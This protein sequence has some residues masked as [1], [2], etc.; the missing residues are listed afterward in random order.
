MPRSQSTPRRGNTHN[1]YDTASNGSV[2]S[3][4]SDS[5]APAPSHGA[6]R[7]NVAQAK[8]IV[9]QTAARKSSLVSQGSRG[10]RPLSMEW[11]PDV[12]N[13]ELSSDEASQLATLDET[14][15][16]TRE[17][18][19]LS[20]SG[21][22]LG[23]TIHG[24][25]DKMHL[26]GDPSIYVTAVI[27]DHAASRDGRL[28]VGDKILS[29]NGLSMENV[30]HLEAVRALKM[31]PRIVSLEVAHGAMLRRK[32]ELLKLRSGLE[33]QTH[34]A[35]IQLHKL[36]GGLGFSIAGGVG[37]PH[38]AGDSGIF[39]VK[40]AAGGAAELD[41]RLSVGDKLLAINGQTCVGIDHDAAVDYLKSAHGAVMLRVEHNAFHKSAWE[42]SKA[43]GLSEAP[44]PRFTRTG[45]LRRFGSKESSGTLNMS[46]TDTE[47]LMGDETASAG[48]EPVRRVTLELKEAKS[49]GFNIIG[50]I[51]AGPPQEEGDLAGVFVSKI[52]D[53]GAAQLV[54]AAAAALCLFIPSRRPSRHVAVAPR[55]LLRSTHRRVCV[56][57]FSCF[58]HL[59]DTP[60]SVERP[61]ERR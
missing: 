31:S 2:S 37:S 7:P 15:P 45:T 49:F 17:T 26:P 30:T 40:M 27:P 59:V 46:T 32:A 42:V 23:M 53:G 11:E 35:E 39:I 19:A 25:K 22:G 57:P 10:G 6:S 43:L 54:C 41:G 1:P 52:I 34:E 29:V 13:P 48:K 55:V 36:N 3:L 47:S 14:V 28:Q 33:L 58:A 24:G 56:P 20:K 16:L 21:G 38:V 61:H 44:Q 50:P 9:S 12:W 8:A 60:L 51:K 5:V 4:A 18:I